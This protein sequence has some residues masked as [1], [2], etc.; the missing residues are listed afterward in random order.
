MKEGFYE[1]YWS[2]AEGNMFDFKIKWPILKK[3]IPPEKG[4]TILDFGCG[5]GAII[6]EMVAINPEAKYIGVD[7]SETALNQARE[8]FPN[9]VFYKINDGGKIPLEN[10]TA[11]FIFSS[12]VL[13]HVY[14]TENA[15]AELQRILKPGGKF[16]LTVPY[17]GFI[18]NFLI[19]AFSF[20]KHFNPAGP[21]IRFFSKKSLFSLLK[22]AGLML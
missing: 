4:K 8:N 9:V 3:F 13:E 19:A 11:D 5:N 18:K 17:H 7:V 21:H 6:K 20:N 2:G 1:K 12:E 22:K 14:D 16:L 10:G 15:L